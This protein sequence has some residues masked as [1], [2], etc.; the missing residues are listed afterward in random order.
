VLLL[1]L[2]MMLLPLLFAYTILKSRRF[3]YAMQ[4][5]SIYNALSAK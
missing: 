3:L 2:L 5:F 1:L 4:L